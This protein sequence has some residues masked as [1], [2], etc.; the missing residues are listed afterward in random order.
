MVLQT[1]HASQLPKLVEAAVRSAADLRNGSARGPSAGALRQALQRWG[2]P[3]PSARVEDEDEAAYEAVEAE[4]FDASLQA[5][6]DE[7]AV[8][9][10]TAAVAAE[11]A[12]ADDE[13]WWATVSATLPRPVRQGSEAGGAGHSQHRAPR[14]R[15]TVWCQL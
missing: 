9:A 7:E 12:E 5:A 15:R 8:E 13:L 3:R 4:P 11:V 14:R 2:L 10:S 6:S 1:H